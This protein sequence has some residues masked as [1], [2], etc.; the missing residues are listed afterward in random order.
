M[1]KYFEHA[2]EGFCNSMEPF[3]HLT[4]VMGEVAKILFVYI[5]IP[6]WVIPY[7]IIRARRTAKKEVVE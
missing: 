5:T 4:Q 6:L 3:V 1:K 7:A 2:Y